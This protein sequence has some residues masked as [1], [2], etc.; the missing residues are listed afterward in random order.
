MKARNQL[1]VALALTSL[2][3]ASCGG[4]DAGQISVT[5]C[6][7]Q[8]DPATEQC[9]NGVCEPITQNPCGNGALDEGEACD[10]VDGTVQFAD[11]SKTTC[12]IFTSKCKFSNQG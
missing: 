8:C 1:L 4:N 2:T 9:V 10:V 11:T 5:E 12:S 6:N 7:P 3:L